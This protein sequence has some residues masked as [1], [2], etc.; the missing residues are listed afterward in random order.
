MKYYENREM[1]RNMEQADLQKMYDWYKEYAR[2]FYTEDQDIQ[3]HIIM[4]E[5]HTLR[6]T[7]Y[8]RQL[9]EHL[10]L[11]AAD[12]L[13]A[14]LIGL[15]HDVGRFKQY[16]L[17]RTFND[18]RS[19]NHALLSLEELA[20]LD[21]PGTLAPEEAEC[22]SFAIANHNALNIPAEATDRQKLHAAIIRD[23]DKLDIYYV[24]TPFLTKSPMEK[25]STVFLDD[26]RYGRQSDYRNMKT[27]DDH[28]LVR[29]NWI[30]DV[31]FSW[32]M[33]QISTKGHIRDIFSHLP[34]TPEI[35]EISRRLQD[36]MTEKSLSGAYCRSI[37]LG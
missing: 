29:L 34:A 35:I 33:Q 30:Y 1:V 23:T 37:R 4:K 15:C 19:V 9:A 10:A 11:S 26:L 18:Q 5:D 36:Y 3:E 24:L 28:K 22:F 21:L 12:R 13:L 17:Y 14:E 31:N 16:S 32:T 7:A 25:L 6:V 8:C 20:K 2:S 27:P